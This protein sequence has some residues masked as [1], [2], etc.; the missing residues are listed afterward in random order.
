MW[1]CAEC[2]HI[3]PGSQ[4]AYDNSIIGGRSG[5][6]WGSGLGLNDIEFDAWLKKQSLIACPKCGYRFSPTTA[7]KEE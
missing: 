2:E 3:F 7:R 4:T 5:Q 1:V 6:F